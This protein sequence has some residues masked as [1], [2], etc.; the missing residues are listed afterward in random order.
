M[1]D[2]PADRVDDGSYLL[3]VVDLFCGAGGFST[4]LVQA[5]LAEFEH[6]IIDDLDIKRED[7]SPRHP[8]VQEWLDENIL[9]VAVNHWDRAVET[10]RANHPWATVH[11]AK[12][13]ALHPPDAVNGHDVDLLIAGPSCVPWSRAKG[14]MAD[15]DQQRMSPRHVSHYIELLRPDQFLLENVTGLLKWGPLERNNDGE[16]EMV[17]DGSLFE[18]WYSTL[19]ALGYSVDYTKLVAADYGDPQSRR[20][21][22][23]M[24]RM[25]YAPAFPEPV[26]SPDGTGETEP[27]RT[28]AD[29]ID[30]SDVGDSLWT[31][32]RP[33]KQKT[34]RRIAAG[35][36][37][38]G[39]KGLGPFA[40]AL[41]QLTKADVAEMQEDTVHVS[42]AAAAA[43]ARDAPFLVEGPVLL[44]SDGNATAGEQ[45]DKRS[46]CLPQVMAGG[47]GGTCRSAADAPVPTVTAKGGAIHFIDPEA[48]VLPRNGRCRGPESNPAYDP[49]EQPLHTVTAKNHDGR[50]FE[51]CLIPLYNEREGQDPRTRDVKRPMMTVPASK[52]PAGISRPFLVKY[53]GQSTTGDITEPL[54]TVTATETLALCVPECYPWGLDIRYRMLKPRELARAQGFPEEYSFKASTKRDTTKLIGNAVPVGLAESLCRSLLVPTNKPTLTKFERSPQPADDD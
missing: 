28:A 8:A 15:D 36:R 4:G 41:A 49:E 44:D 43:E 17:K 7:I 21:L 51:A 22:F 5:I 50:K 35:I 45:R 31:K 16:L 42:D 52:V 11:N 9:H 54:P 3:V 10:F 1:S 37:E 38:Y 48:F 30:W 18:D 25:N 20:R 32:S 39:H 24:G 23:V 53:Y 27:Y 2:E 34:N 14:G 33:L 47:G 29:I 26:H 46:I 6:Q 40:D 13:Q 12:V 19:Q